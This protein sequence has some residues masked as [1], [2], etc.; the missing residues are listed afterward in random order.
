MIGI[1]AVISILAINK[2]T[3]KIKARDLIS[4]TQD[5]TILTAKE[6]S[7]RYEIVKNTVDTINHN[8]HSGEVYYY[9][10]SEGKFIKVSGK[11]RFKLEI[12]K[13]STDLKAEKED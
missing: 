2:M 11:K 12:S 13:E 5:T 1:T 9:K 6:Y 4:I 3:I 7:E 8:L 10:N